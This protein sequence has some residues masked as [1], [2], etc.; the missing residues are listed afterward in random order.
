M[1]NIQVQVVKNIVKDV[2]IDGR[3]SVN[4]RIENFKTKS[5]VPKLILA[6]YHLKMAD[7]SMVKPSGIIKNLKI[8]THGTPYVTT[9]T[10]WVNN[11]VD[12]NYYMLLGK[13]LFKDA[14]VTHDWGNNVIIVQGN[15]IIRTISINKKLGAKNRRPQVF[16]CYDSLVRL[17]NEKEDM[18]F[19]KNTK[20]LSI[21]TIIISNEKISL[22]SIG[23]SIVIFDEKS[24]P[25]QGTSDRG[26]TKVVPST[27]KFHVKQD[28]SLED[29]VYPKT[30]YH[31]SQV[32]IEVDETPKKI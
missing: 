8:R 17:I 15:G 31:H 16:V 29:K 18:I 6:P 2:L 24:N 25:K 1:A 26:I 19:E 20:L 28:I 5:S 22:L 3:A 27:T 12:S 32:D 11:V 4:I 7:H 30:Y 13:P 10:V 23:M 9:F 14:K 21:G